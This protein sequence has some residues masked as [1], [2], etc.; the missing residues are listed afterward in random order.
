MPI[1]VPIKDLKDTAKFAKLVEE[2]PGPVTVTRNGYDA[3]V[4]MRSADYDELVRSSPRR[5]L[6]DRIALADREIEEG[7]YWDCAEVSEDLRGRYGL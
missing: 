2:A 1:C 3:F 6:L 7:R 5:R 4:V